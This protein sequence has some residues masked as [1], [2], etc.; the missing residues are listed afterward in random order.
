MKDKLKE[1][2]NDRKKS[3]DGVEAA[4]FAILKS[5]YQI[6]LPAYHGGKT[7]RR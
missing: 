3:G 2:K 6:Q 7:A 5:C 4:M 1:F